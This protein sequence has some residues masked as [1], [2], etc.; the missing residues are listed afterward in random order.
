MESGFTRKKVE[1]LTLGEKLRKLRSDFRMSLA[2]VSKVTRIQ[3]KYLELLESGEYE[4]LPADVYVRG[5]LRSYARYLNVDEQALVRL[6]ERERNIR[7]NLGRKSNKPVTTHSFAPISIVITSR[8]VM[9]GVI[10][11][12]VFGAFFYLYQ[13]FKSF[14]ADPELVIL[15]PQ[16]SAVIENTEVVVRGKTDK[17]AQVSLNNQVVFVD[18]E[19]LFSDKLSLQPGINTV[20]VRTVN[21]FDKEKTVTFSVDARY[22]PVVP[23]VTQSQETLAA[24]E[25]FSLEVIADTLPLVL[26]VAADG[27][28]VFSGKLA[29]G[30]TKT[31][32]GNE[33][34]SITTD[35]GEATFVRLNGTGEKEA[36]SSTEGPLK[37]AL[38]GRSGRQGS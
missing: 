35:R 12:L 29:A 23:A 22:T 5:F 18:G 27:V 34:V 31:F 10:V 38:F 15:E 13:E 24:Q 8:S 6:Y 32:T 28:V 30:E 26:Q 37:D 36:L 17:G 14:A 19:G 33:Q 9:V 16:H 11:L 20:E 7:E 4:K 3:V 1:S 2:D 25:T 21:R